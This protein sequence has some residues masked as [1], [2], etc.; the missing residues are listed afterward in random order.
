MNGSS[1][2]PSASAAP[3][4]SI[5]L[6]RF[7]TEVVRFAFVKPAPYNP[8][9][10]SDAALDGLEASLETFG[11]LQPMIYNERTRHI[12]GGH[13]RFKIYERRGMT[14]AEMIVVDMDPAAERAANVALNSPSI[15]GE[16]TEDLQ[17]LLAGI[18]LDT[19]EIYRSMLLE[20][21]RETIPDPSGGKDPGANLALRFGV[22]PLS[23]LDSRQGYWQARKTAWISIGIE[24]ELGRG[25]N[26]LK[27]SDT[28]LEPDPEKRARKKQSGRLTY[29]TGVERTDEVSKKII[30]TGRRKPGTVGEIKTV[31]FDG[32]DNYQGSGTSI[33]DPVLAEVAYR[34][35]CPTA[36]QVY[37]PFAGGSVRGIVAARLGLKYTG[38]DLRKEQVDA[39]D[40]QAAKL[41]KRKADR[42]TWIT[43]DSTNVATLAP[44]LQSD[45]VFSCPPYGDLEVYSDDPADLSTMEWDAFVR[46]YRQIIREAVNTLRNDRFCVFVVGEVRGKA[47]MGAYRGLVPE[48]IRAFQEAGA[49]FYNEAILVNA[50]G[51]AALRAASNLTKGR[52]ITKVH[53]NVLTF[54]KGDPRKASAACDGPLFQFGEPEHTDEQTE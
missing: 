33:F 19:P 12:V 4:T 27:M 1:A 7:R 50:I 36:G 5:D 10:I 30:A 18:E 8:R 37:D 38:I 26:L 31:G 51:S 11:T 40:A 28:L 41:I 23:V 47:N 16:F 15:T 2:K 34:W 13:Q 6:G 48:T 21:L 3:P 52:K 29:A 35:F 9:R 22:P 20:Q 43:G 54:V 49:A 44:A 46:A 45:F 14:E 24:S 53:Q 25:E 42:P 39:N 17:A 32:G